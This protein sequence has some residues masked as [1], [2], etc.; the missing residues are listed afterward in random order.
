M[1]MLIATLLLLSFGS[2][3][4]IAEGGGSNLYVF[5]TMLQVQTGNYTAQYSQNG[6]QRLPGR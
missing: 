6:E 1:K 5:E 4:V 3:F 2:S